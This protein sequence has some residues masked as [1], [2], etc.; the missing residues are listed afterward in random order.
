[1]RCVRDGGTSVT[2]AMKV[3]CGCWVVL[4]LDLALLAA[5]VWGVWKVCQR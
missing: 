2:R 3:L 5:A 4:L 1:M